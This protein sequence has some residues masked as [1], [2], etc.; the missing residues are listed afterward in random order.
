MSRK[1]DPNDILLL[2]DNANKDPKARKE[3]IKMFGFILHPNFGIYGLIMLIINM[4]TAALIIGFS[5]LISPIIE[6]TIIGFLL[7]ILLYT[8]IELTIKLLLLRFLLKQV[9]YSLGSIFYILYVGIFYLVSI[10]VPNPGFVFPTT[11]NLFVFV[12]IFIIV[13]MAFSTL[14]RKNIFIQKIGGKKIGK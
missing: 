8:L 2:V 11:E 14:I 3:L 1:P 4:L 13:R 10:I 12:V 6:V 7:G 9:I 5:N